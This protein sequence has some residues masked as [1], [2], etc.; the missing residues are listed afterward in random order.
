MQKFYYRLLSVLV[1]V[2]V[3]INITTFFAGFNTGQL[4]NISYF[5]ER[6]T[7]EVYLIKHIILESGIYLKN[8][9]VT[10]LA[11][12]TGK[13]A[14]KYNINEKLLMLLIEPKSEFNISLTGGMG[15]SGICDTYFNDTEFSDPFN[16]EQNIFA[17]AETLASLQMQEIPEDSL[18]STFILCHKK[19]KIQALYPEIYENA[20]KLDKTYTGILNAKF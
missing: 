3:L 7:A 4:I 1:G 12:I 18:P 20:M 11:T 5:K 19:D 13:A 2:A 16:P 6:T 15:L 9:S 10:D 14:A 17:T 8:T